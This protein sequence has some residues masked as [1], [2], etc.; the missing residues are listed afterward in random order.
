MTHPGF[1]SDK[2]MTR[3]RQL[4]PYLDDG[5][6]LARLAP[7]AGVSERTLH[8]WLSTYRRD[9]IEG[10]DDKPR[11]DRGKRRKLDPVLE[12]TIRKEASKKPRPLVT[13]IH[14]RIVQTAEKRGLTSPSYATV[15]QVVRSI[16]LAAIALTSKDCAA[17]RDQYEIVHR[18][19]ASAPN[20]MWQ[21]D[22]TLLD[23]E[24]LDAQGEIVRPWLSLVVDDYSRAICGYF[25]SLGAPSAVNTA[26]ALR[27]AIWRKADPVWPVCGIP[28]TLYVDN[29]SDFISEHIEQ[30]CIALKIRLVHSMPGRPRGRGRIERLF[31]TVNDMFLAELPGFLKDGKSQSSPA[32]TEEAFSNRF[33]DFLHNTYHLRPHGT[34]GEP[35]VQRWSNGGFLPQL[36]ESLE[37]LDMLLLRV[38][39]LRKVQRDGIRFKGKR[40]MAV[41]LAAYVGES[42]GVL[43]DPRDLA[44]IRVYHDGQFV[45]RAVCPEHFQAPVLS[46]I[47]NARRQQKKTLRS[48][49]GLEPRTGKPDRQ[50]SKLMLYA[51]ED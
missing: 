35:P 45:C 22:H 11:A 36:P 5:V 51:N 26:L 31:R 4:Q 28:Q 1:A 40:Y 41:T 33:E 43:F 29:G 39:R 2:A 38:A 50:K 32:L 49:A 42:V 46:D 44:E 13:V 3:Y 6:P 19:E 16:P 15:A 25:L 27:Q 48:E 17:Y 23:I 30:A 9:G 14:R 20:E 12:T 34:T 18:R 47:F 21:A 37:A 10:L 24:L 7:E 8:R